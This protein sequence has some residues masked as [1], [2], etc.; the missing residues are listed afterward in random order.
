MAAHD[1][2]ENLR[3]CLAA[4]GGLADEV[5]VVD[6]E[7]ADA[8]A[9]V[10]EELGARVIRTTN[11]PMLEVN[12]NIAMAAASHRWVLV[13]DPDERISAPLREQIAAVVE[14]DDRRFAGYWMA[15]RNY[16]LGAWI[17]TMGMYPGYQLRLVRHGHGRFGEIDHHLPMAV[18]GATGYLTGDLIH[19]SDASVA[20]ILAKRRLYAEFAAGQMHS[21]GVRFRVHRLLSAPLRSFAG[22][23]LLLGGWLE[24][25]RGLL[26]AGLSAYGAFLRQARL[27]E[28]ERKDRDGRA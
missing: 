1:E 28:L 16:I 24:G 14:R 2:E 20:E 4:L 22:Q 5:V 11:K 18:E 8:S 3:E 13:L 23:Y 19:L 12:K 27:W 17:R 7:S 26:Y 21:R 15:R 9:E 6:A 25:V 10:A